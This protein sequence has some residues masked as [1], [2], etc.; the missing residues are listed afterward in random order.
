MSIN[1]QRNILITSEVFDDH[2]N[3]LVAGELN[4]DSA[5]RL[6]KEIRQF[7]E[8][9]N[10]NFVINIE[11][12]NLITSAG[13][14]VLLVLA[15]HLDATGGGIAL[16]GPKPSVREIFEIT[17]F[18]SILDLCRTYENATLALGS[19]AVDSG[20]VRSNQHTEAH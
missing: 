15:K 9:G 8:R 1:K 4:T 17:G 3:V 20:S 18:N 5:P 19:T 10:A 11:N 16:Y 13:L 12:L 2:V 6:E 14:R 7:I